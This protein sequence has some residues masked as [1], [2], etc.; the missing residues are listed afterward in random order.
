MLELLK[1]NEYTETI[2]DI[3]FDYYWDKGYECLIVDIDN[4]LTPW[5]NFE[6]SNNLA[7]LIEYLKKK[8]Y[9][10]CLLSNNKQHKVQSFA[11][12]LGVAAAPKGGKPF[13]SAFKRALKVLQSRAENTLLVGDQIFTDIFG[14]NR[15][16]LYTILVDPI[17]KKEFIGTKIVRLI[18][19]L[20]RK[21]GV[22]KNEHISYD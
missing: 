21:R 2:Y 1:P 15:M 11:L 9:R 10:I 14:G 16:G 19:R 22:K 6:I 17:D 20:V 13:L 18:E 5:N 7:N 4:T 8:G 12:K 3:D